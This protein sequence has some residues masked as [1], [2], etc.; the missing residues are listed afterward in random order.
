MVDGTGSCT[1]AVF[2][3]KS[4]VQVYVHGFCKEQNVQAQGPL[5]LVQ[6]RHA[7]AAI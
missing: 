5:H 1:V 7:R 3:E 2:T 4:V 6:Q